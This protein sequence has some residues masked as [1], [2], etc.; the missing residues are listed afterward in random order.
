[1]IVTELPGQPAAWPVRDAAG[2]HYLAELA[3]TWYADDYWTLAPPVE[4]G[5]DAPTR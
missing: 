4:A 2:Q 5:S 3:V 1:M